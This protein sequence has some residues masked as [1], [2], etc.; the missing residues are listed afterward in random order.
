[1]NLRY[2]NRLN[3]IKELDNFLSSE[4]K[5]R[6]EGVEQV[7]PFRSNEYYLSL[8]DWRD[9]EDP[10]RKIIIPDPH[11]LE[12]KGRLDPS[13]EKD[14]TIIPGLQHKYPQTVL[15]LLS[16]VCGGICRFCFRKRLFLKR[17]HE[18]AP[19]IPACLE[20][21]RCHEEIT[22][23]LLTGGDPLMLSTSYLEKVIQ[24]LRTIEHVQIIRIG[25][26]LPAYNPHRI[27]DDSSLLELFR[28]YST[29]KKRIYV[30]A[31]FNHPRELTESAIRALETLR[32]AG[33]IVVNQ[34]P[35]I[36]G[37]NDS[38]HILA[39]LFRRLSFLGVSPYY[40][41][42]CR[43]TIGN[44]LFTV[45]VETSFRIVHEAFSLCSGL[46]K[47]ARFIMSHASGKIEIVGCTADRVFM[48]YHQAARK[49]DQGRFM[50]FPSNPEACWL[51]DYEDALMVSSFRR[52]N[53][54]HPDSESI[55]S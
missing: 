55:A 31:Q 48:R 25:S 41:F 27:L 16:D 3:Q 4:E 1:M 13:S 33:V 52:E 9:P 15:V 49:E 50:I 21:I 37:V 17:E 19:D 43:P 40:V 2:M 42:Q 54:L 46:A 30:M 36:A 8:I 23:V 22:D 51:D 38:P 14:Y 24:A 29:P 11:E 34:T 18:V 53:I 28:R 35:L 44:R 39:E 26:K 10:L 12:P 6:L 47:R 7:F 5:K 32:D 45:P 20:Y